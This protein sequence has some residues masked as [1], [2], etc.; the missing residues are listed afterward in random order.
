[1]DYRLHQSFF[2]TWQEECDKAQNADPDQDEQESA[3]DAK[4][5]DSDKESTSSFGFQSGS[6]DGKQKRKPQAK[7]N[8]A[9]IPKRHVPPEGDENKDRQTSAPAAGESIPSQKAAEKTRKGT[10]QVD[11]RVAAS[12]KSKPGQ[13]ASKA[14]L[15]K[16]ERAFNA[17]KKADNSLKEISCDMMWRSII[18]IGEIE[19]RLQKSDMA[20]RELATSATEGLYTDEKVVSEVTKLLA[21]MTE[22]RQCITDVKDL[23]REVRSWTSEQAAKTVSGQGENSEACSL[24]LK[25]FHLFL[26]ERDINTMMEMLTSLARK[27]MD[28]TWFCRFALLGFRGEGPAGSGLWFVT[29]LSVHS[30]QPEAR[31]LGGQPPIAENSDPPPPLKFK[32]KNNR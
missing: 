11:A 32:T 23:C 24:F 20:E 8:A 21:E 31:D 14:K 25:A 18:R 16:A 7:R 10:A 12:A 17:A 27:L 2:H 29:W 15:D 28:V 19:R 3:S 13:R 26:N 30:F 22:Y 9:P 4:E 6:E 1:M 5:A